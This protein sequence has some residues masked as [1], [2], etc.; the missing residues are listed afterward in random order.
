MTARTVLIIDDDERVRQQVAALV[1]KAGFEP[2]LFEKP[3]RALD[4]LDDLTDGSVVMVIAEM[5]MP[6]MDGVVFL[7]ETKKRQHLKNPPFLFLSGLNDTIM[8]ITAYQEGAVDYFFKPIQKEKLFVAK[9][10]SMV[11][12]YD[13]TIHSAN[14]VV[15]G[16]LS[17]TSLEDILNV[18]H[19]EALSGFL[20][21]SSSTNEEGIITFSKGLP[22]SIQIMDKNRSVVVSDSEAFDRMHNWQ[23]GEFVVFRGRLT[24]T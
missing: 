19:Q 20:K 11:A 14:I 7:K 9:I 3:Q 24:E 2:M 1:R 13:A 4:Y 17:Q 8:L 5:T 10:K 15:A 6:E 22:E 21:I 23:D 12:S 18:C 16:R